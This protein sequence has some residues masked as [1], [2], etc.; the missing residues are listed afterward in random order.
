MSAARP[1]AVRLRS[2]VSSALPALAAVLASV[3]GLGGLVVWTAAGAAGTA[4]ELRVTGA[5]VLLPSVGNDT[6]AAVFRIR[7]DGGAPVRLT[8]V[9][10]PAMGDAMLAR[11]EPVG[12]GAA[13][14]S[15]L[16]AVTVPARGTLAMSP[17]GIDVMV[18]VLEPLRV[19]QRVPF[20]LRFD[21]GGRLETEAVVVRPTDWNAP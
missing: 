2:W 16:E 7:N 14:M 1:A 18:E 11:D 3:L 8:D 9:T 6:T 20:V 13:R 5:R 19:G 15:M 17:Y 12:D 21:D 4:S 10:S